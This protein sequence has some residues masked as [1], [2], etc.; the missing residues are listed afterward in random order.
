L[1][2]EIEAA[3]IKT[4]LG[5]LSKMKK[6]LSEFFAKNIYDFA[7]DD[8]TKKTYIDLIKD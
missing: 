2:S 1:L 5:D 3:A 6:E 8:E 4:Q 7:E